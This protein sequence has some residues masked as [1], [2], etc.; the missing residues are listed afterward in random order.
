MFVLNFEFLK[1]LISVHSLKVVTDN[2]LMKSFWE[3]MLV[4]VALRLH[5]GTVLL[6]DVIIRNVHWE[7]SL[8][9]PGAFTLWGMA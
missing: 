4:K 6:T 8:S 1:L 7:L 2:G 3:I 5:E 9:R